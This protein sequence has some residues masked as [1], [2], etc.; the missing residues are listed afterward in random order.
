MSQWREFC[1]AKLNLYLA[2]TGRRPDG[3]H[4]L[5]SLVVKLDIGDTLEASARAWGADSLACDDAEL[6]TG[7][8]NLV[9][10]AAAAYRRKV[11]EAPFMDWTLS[12]HLPC[13]AGLGGG[14]SDAAA[15]LRIMNAAC[16]NALGAEDM[17]AVASEAG[18]DCPLFLFDGPCLMR[19]RGELLEALPQAAAAALRGRGVVVLKPH[20]GIPTGWAYSA[21]AGAGSCIPGQEAEAEL[22]AWLAAPEGPPPMR[23]SFQDVVFRKYP[24]YD[25][26]NAA[27]VGAGLPA[28]RL[29]GSGSACHAFAQGDAAERMLA[30]G[31]DCLGEGSFCAA[32]M[33][34]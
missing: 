26:L 29:T 14:S 32:A 5:V 2:V 30:V 13:G 17:L 8:D 22:A 3:Y 7:P 23:N 6:P 18:S 15:A 19:G 12:K 33:I 25:V 1:P 11:T 34:V 16:C 24:C 21:L 31:R 10:K 27:L 9:L 4:D 20:F 28:M